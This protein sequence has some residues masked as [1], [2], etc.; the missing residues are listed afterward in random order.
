MEKTT[1]EKLKFPIGKHQKLSEYSNEYLSGC[2]NQIEVFPSEIIKVVSQ[3]SDLQLDTR[4]RE[5]GWSI[6]QVV[7]HCADSHMN[8]LIRFKLALTE[9]KPSIRPYYEDRWAELVDSIT[10]PIEPSLKILEG[11]HARWV[12]LLRSLS[13]EDL[14]RTFI[15]PESGEEV[16]LDENISIYAW[17]CRH[18][19]AHITELIKRKGW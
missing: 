13:N 5:S 9:E 12:L 18:H 15:H 11:I 16:A 6:R 7:H 2:I 1:L 17:H 3:L 4:Y 19:L 14:C 10:M 8:S